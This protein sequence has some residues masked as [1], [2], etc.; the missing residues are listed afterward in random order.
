[1]YISKMLWIIFVN[2]SMYTNTFEIKVTEPCKENERN[3][4][5][6]EGDIIYIPNNKFAYNGS[7]IVKK[8][9][10]RDIQVLLFCHFIY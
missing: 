9:L 7:L 3:S 1:M 8:V 4:A 2:Y 6:Y 5:K 10:P